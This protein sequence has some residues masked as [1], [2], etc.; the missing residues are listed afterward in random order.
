MTLQRK[1]N[2]DGGNLGFHWYVAT[3]SCT[4]TKV[5]TKNL[6]QKEDSQLQDETF[7]SL[8]THIFLQKKKKS[9]GRNKKSHMLMR[10]SFHL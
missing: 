4:Y 7:Q 1:K 6:L 10:T 8:R 3:V 9:K 5:S 2:A